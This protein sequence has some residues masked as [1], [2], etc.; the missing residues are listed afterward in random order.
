MSPRK[1]RTPPSTVDGSEKAGLGIEEA[2]VPFVERDSAFE[3]RATDRAF[4]GEAVAV[5]T[6]YAPEIF[7]RRCDR[8]SRLGTPGSFSGVARRLASRT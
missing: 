8:E 7:H 4:E 6:P 3:E 1:Q 2:E 5:G